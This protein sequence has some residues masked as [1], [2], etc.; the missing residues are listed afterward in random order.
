[1]S[2]FSPYQQYKPSLS[3]ALPVYV[4][5][6]F[7]MFAGNGQYVLEHNNGLHGVTFHD[8]VKSTLAGK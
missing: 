4:G 7:R 6:T 5:V 2:T 8:N 3:V 1:M